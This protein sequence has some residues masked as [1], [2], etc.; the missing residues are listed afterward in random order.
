MYIVANCSNGIT[1]IKND[2]I[3][4]FSI[5]KNATS[6][7]E[8]SYGGCCISSFKCSFFYDDY[9]EYNF[10]D[11]ILEFYNNEDEK[12]GEFYVDTPDIQNGMATLNCSDKLKDACVYWKGRSF[13][14]SLWELFTDILNQTHISTK[15]T[16]SDLPCSNIVINGNKDFAT[17]TCKDLLSYIAEIN[18]GFFFIDNDG[19]ITFKS[20]NFKSPQQ[21]DNEYLD[22]VNLEQISTIRNGVVIIVKG[23]KNEFG[24]MQNALIINENVI[25]NTLDID[26]LNFVGNYLTNIIIDTDYFAG[27]VSLWQDDK[28]IELGDVVEV[29]DYYG[30][31]KKIIVHE[32]SYSNDF[33]Y[34]DIESYGD[35]ITTKKMDSSIISSFDEGVG[36]GNGDVDIGEGKNWQKIDAKQGSYVICEK[37]ITN[38]SYFTQVYLSLFVQFFYNV[39]KV[40]DFKI[41][42]NN[43]YI[44]NVPT[45]VH[46][47]LNVISAGFKAD[48]DLDSENCLYSCRVDIEDGCEL[49]I[50]QFSAR[51]SLIVVN[52]TIENNIAG[53][54]YFIEKVRPIYNTILNQK[55]LSL[56]KYRDEMEMKMPLQ[57]INVSANTSVDDV[58][59]TLYG[60]YSMELTGTGKVRSYMKIHA[61]GEIAKQFEDYL[62]N[63]KSLYVGSGVTRLGEGALKDSTKLER[64]EFE[65]AIEIQNDVF[66]NCSSLKTIVFGGDTKIYNYAF[67]YCKALET[68]YNSDKVNY[69][70]EYAFYDATCQSS[71]DFSNAELG[72]NAFERFTCPYV[73]IGK[74]FET[75]QKYIFNESNVDSCLVYQNNGADYFGDNPF[76]SI[77][78]SNQNGMVSTFIFNH[79][80]SKISFPYTDEE[81]YGNKFITQFLNTKAT[82]KTIYCHEVLRNRIYNIVSQDV[83]EQYNCAIVTF[84]TEE[85]FNNII[86]EVWDIQC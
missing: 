73:K 60:D 29:I 37:L 10:N 24:S 70:G 36:S 39:D 64:V 75:I 63:C 68:I 82:N 69:I 54:Q 17:I 8:F 72:Y 66:R 3:K 13:P 19:Y 38:T 27:K 57:V 78:I 80:V 79:E 52:G 6:Q 45:K 4:N 55:K 15:I 12:V 48:V 2:D 86:S 49:I 56:Y 21:Y 76:C 42:A 61:M 83:I 14:C 40:L 16:K 5:V 74:D 50:N 51:L 7:N 31:Y 71:I 30:N 11:A 53:N 33:N 58:Y 44:G 41:Y 1:T 77:E 85:E 43:K 28:K 9:K 26:N 62:I 81:E 23:E 25:I 84:T 67:G 20:F 34:V 65:D 46:Q 32:L 18:G 22:K 47:G 59:L 35:N